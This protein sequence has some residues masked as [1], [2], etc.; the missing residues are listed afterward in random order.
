[1]LAQA[2]GEGRPSDDPG[3]LLVLDQIQRSVGVTT[4][5]SPPNSRTVRSSS[6]GIVSGS[7]TH[8]HL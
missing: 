6:A 1:M 8:R 2:L 4:K 7:V 5:V 3:G